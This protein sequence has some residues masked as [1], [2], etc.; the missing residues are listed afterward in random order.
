MNL[1]RRFPQ[2][3]SIVLVMAAMLAIAVY[4]AVARQPAATAPAED[5]GP[6]PLKREELEQL[7]AP[8][9]L[10]PDSLLTQMLMAS[11]YPLEI[12]QADR[13]AKEHKD[14]KD[15]A[16]TA[17]LEK[18]TWDPAVRSLVNFPEVL[19][20]MS[21]KLDLTIKLGDAFIA[22][23]ADVMNTVQNLRAKA[24]A[25]GNLK[26]NDQQNV[27][28]E[29]PP[30]AQQTTVIVEQAAPPPTQIIKIEPTQPQVIYV[31]SY[32]PTYVYGGWPYPSYPPAP[33]Y[34]P[35][36]VASN[37]I[38]FGVGVA[39]GAAWGYAW[40]NC[41]W[42]GNDVDIDIDRNT[43]INNNIDRSKYKAEFQ[44]RQT[45]V[46]RG[47]GGRAGAQGQGK[48]SWSHN[49]QHREGVPYRDNKTAQQFGGTTRT[50]Q[51]N[52]ARSAYSG[53]AEAGRQDLARG[54]ASEYR[55]SGAQNRAGGAGAQGRGGPPHRP[56]TPERPRP[57]NWAPPAASHSVSTASDPAAV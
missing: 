34:P 10:Y 12:V 33:Y 6:P 8:I 47:E 56:R 55:G 53:R 25:E 32:S 9:A 36:Y 1:R 43:N 42:G 18:Q 20:M 44:N 50:Q 37:M 29:A 24:Q 7:L 39:C 49:P 15:A 3:V 5:A 54:G 52:Q 23:Q 41:N 19:A 40:G 17:E 11:T 38:S 48:G 2:V 57:P 30:P 28:V 31:P 4:P 27:I 26:S 45:N 35:G 51:A 16:L 46:Q 22:Q 21:E 13:W 14:L